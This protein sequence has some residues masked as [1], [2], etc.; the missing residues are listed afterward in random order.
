MRAKG[1]LPPCLRHPEALSL[2]TYAPF[3]PI[4]WW[5][6]I[7]RAHK[8]FDKARL[9]MSADSAIVAYR[10]T[11]R[12]SERSFG[13]TFAVALAVFAFWPLVFRLEM[14]RL[15]ALVISLAFL[16]SALVVPRLLVPLNFLWF[17]FGMLLHQIVNPI[18]MAL[19]YYGAVVP[20]GLVLTTAGKDLLRLKGDPAANSYWIVR[21][22]PGPAAGT[23]AKQ[24]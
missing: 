24:F 3:D 12:S 16:T 1:L 10:K 8:C 13:V 21:D 11:I 7:G 22:P 5:A 14:P 2:T 19:I 20:M 9:E 4:F 18:L 6:M 15:W 17:K 23:M